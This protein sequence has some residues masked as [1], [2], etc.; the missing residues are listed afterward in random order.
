[1]RAYS[2]GHASPNEATQLSYR[3]AKVARQESGHE[4]SPPSPIAPRADQ[5]EDTGASLRVRDLQ[6]LAPD[7][8]VETCVIHTGFVR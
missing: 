3:Q 4:S 5:G 1:M 2:R 8:T 6:G 7:R